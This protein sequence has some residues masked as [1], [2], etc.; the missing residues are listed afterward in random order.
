MG[1]PM[2]CRRITQY[3][4]CH[5][6]AM[7]QGGAKQ[8]QQGVARFQLMNYGFD[9]AKVGTMEERAG[10]TVGGTAEERIKETCLHV[11]KK[12]ARGQQAEPLMSETQKHM[13]S[14]RHC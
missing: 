2:Y 5:K 13:S 12:W 7:E 9:P 10:K 4:N 1:N 14:W 11:Q 8:Q 3:I 6:T